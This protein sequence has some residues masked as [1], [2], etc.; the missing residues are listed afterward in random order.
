MMA[1][2]DLH[3]L[4]IIGACED[5]FKAQII[6]DVFSS[7]GIYV[8]IQGENNHSLYGKVG[9]FIEM[10]ILVKN[11]DKEKAIHLLKDLMTL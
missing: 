6:R 5:E 9:S 1:K 7:H 10:N 8:F 11:K 3:E 4:I 2:Q